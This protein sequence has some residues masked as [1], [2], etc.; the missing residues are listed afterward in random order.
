M[1]RT[2]VVSILA[3]SLTA[4]AVGGASGGAQGVAGAADGS[5]RLVGDAAGSSFDVY[6]FAFKVRVDSDGTVT[7]QYR[8]TQRRDGVELRIS[9]PL[10]CAT[11][12]GNR[13][14]VGGVIKETTRESLRGLDMWFQVQDNGD[15]DESSLDM[16]STVGAGGPGTALKYCVD[17][18]PV[19]FPFFVWRGDIAVRG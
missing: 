18:P 4:F 3:G 1:R 8:Y 12:S 10:T 16:S 11:I 19:L 5:Y 2:I 17:A 14:W 13:A 9:G 15:G 6:P 7:G